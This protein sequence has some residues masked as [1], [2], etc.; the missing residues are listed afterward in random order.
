MKIMAKVGGGFDFQTYVILL[1]DQTDGRMGIT[2]P[3]EVHI[4]IMRI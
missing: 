1:K 2:T 4:L 3:M